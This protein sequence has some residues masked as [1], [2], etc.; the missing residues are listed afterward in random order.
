MTKEEFFENL[1][2]IK[3]DRIYLTDNL[4]ELNLEIENNHWSIGIDSVTAKQ[5]NTND[6]EGFLKEMVQNRTRQLNESDKEIG[7]LFYAWFD[8]QSGNLNFNFINSGHKSLPFAAEIMFVD[9]IETIL[10][11][12]L[13]S[14]YLDG[15]PMNELEDVSG[16]SDDNEEREF[17]LKVYKE[18]IPGSTKAQ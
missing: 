4:E 15:I 17:K 13:N 5:V 11:D 3:S 8:E 16:N 10:N 18:K 14:E 6:L 12:F 1:D 2:E 7:L 9:S